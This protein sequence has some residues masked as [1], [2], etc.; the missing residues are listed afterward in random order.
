MSIQLPTHDNPAP[1][2]TVST[3]HLKL[4]LA[5]VVARRNRLLARGVLGS[6][7]FR[8][9]DVPGAYGAS[10]DALWMALAFCACLR[11]KELHMLTLQDIRSSSA[12]DALDI[13]VQHTKN[14]EDGNVSGEGARLRPAVVS[15]S[16]HA[17]LAAHG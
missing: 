1:V 10:R 16:S 15:G 6:G 12:P 11:K 5:V 7:S 8:Q 9:G 4:L 2:L 3:A 14:N 13:N 17:H